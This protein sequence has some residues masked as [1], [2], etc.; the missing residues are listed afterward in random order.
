MW[1]FIKA[2]WSS[3]WRQPFAV[4]T[5]FAYNLVW[6][7]VIYKLVQS[8]VV[9]LLHRYPGKQL[10]QEAVQLFWIEG[11][12]QLMKTDLAAPYIGWGLTLVLLRMALSP[13]LNAGIYYSLQHPELNAGYRFV[14]GVR[15][16]SWP[17]LGLY[18]LQT[19]LALAPLYWL[20]PRAASQFA[21]Q[22]SY[23][24]LGLD[25]LPEAA[26][27]AIYLFLLQ[28]CFSL[29][30]IGKAAERTLLYTLIFALRHLGTA[31]LL[32]LFVALAAGLLSA[33]VTAS[34]FIWAG[35][36]A[37]IGFQAYRLIHMFCKI[38]AISTQYALWAEKSRSA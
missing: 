37:L 27:Y 2:G 34:A 5:L 6:G 22:T 32:T 3:A 24:G 13:V 18:A 29:L 12:F 35:F 30:M 16:L 21:K 26:G 31:A 9:P 14:Q 36:A 28:L 15:K 8:I 23:I 1:T 33:A 25:L 10:S 20:I 19:L 17:Y 11:Q 38:W 4:F 7:V